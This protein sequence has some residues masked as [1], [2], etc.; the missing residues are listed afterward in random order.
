MDDELIQI[1]PQSRVNEP[2]LANIPLYKKRSPPHD[3]LD[4]LE[5][6][7]LT[8]TGFFTHD[9]FSTSWKQH[10]THM[11]TEMTDS[12][13]YEDSHEHL[14]IRTTNSIAT[15]NF[16]IRIRTRIFSAE[17]AKHASV[18]ILVLLS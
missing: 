10:D 9:N 1:L 4:P 7:K 17:H 12:A 15:A 5:C 8:I 14:Q 2:L 16:C 6:L 11:R 18:A 13:R 3:A